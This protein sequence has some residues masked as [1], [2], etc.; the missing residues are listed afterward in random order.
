MFSFL[1]PKILYFPCYVE[2]PMDFKSKRIKKKKK[3]KK[4]SKDFLKHL[5]S[6]GQME[7]FVKHKCTF[8]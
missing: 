6:D 4:N 3:K 1:P 5:V 7:L 2:K 8:I